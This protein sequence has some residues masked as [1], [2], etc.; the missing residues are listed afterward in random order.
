APAQAAKV[1]AE[2][3]PAKDR[4]RAVD[5]RTTW[6]RGSDDGLPGFV[7]GGLMVLAI[8]VFALDFLPETAEL[9]RLLYISES[10]GA[11]FPGLPEV[12]SGQVWRLITP[13][14]LHFGLMHIFFNLYAIALVGTM[15]ER[16][17][18]SVFT[19]VLT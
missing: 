11:P 1:V 8:G 9:K 10:V 7:C 5:V 19:A 2:T 4:H 13:I 3:K 15:I 6:G 16:L 17:E 14:F 18:G 12:F